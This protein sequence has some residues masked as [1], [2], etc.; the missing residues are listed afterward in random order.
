MVVLSRRDDLQMRVGGS[1]APTF[2]SQSASIE[3]F[4]TLSSAVLPTLLSSHHHDHTGV[5]G[6]I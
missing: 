1:A 3:V 5:L 6:R 2:V 4:A